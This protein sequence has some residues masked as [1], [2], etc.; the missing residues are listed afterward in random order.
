MSCGGACRAAATG[1][2]RLGE[3][4][5]IEVTT[6]GLLVRVAKSLCSSDSGVVGNAVFVGLLTNKGIN[7]LSVVLKTRSRVV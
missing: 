4:G 2:G 5:G 1:G 7:G 6:V 3:V